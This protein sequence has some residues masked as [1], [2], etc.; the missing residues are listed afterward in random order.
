MIMIF[1]LL[2]AAAAT[3]PPAADAASHGP[4]Q[5]F[6]A[7]S[8]EPFRVYGDV[9]YP[10]ANW[11]TAADKNADGKLDLAEFT[12]DFLRFFDQ[13]DQNHDGAIDGIEKARY[14]NEVAPETTGASWYAKSQEQTNYEW[15]A[16][17][18][19]DVNLPKVDRPARQGQEAPIGA[20]R[21]DLLGLPEPV[22]SMD[23]EV[24]GRISRRMATDVAQMRFN[25]LDPQHR[26]FLTLDQLPRTPAEGRGGDRKRR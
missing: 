10:V 1:P 17:F 2:L 23:L 18:S 7:P 19:K 24:R 12:A 8:G 6:I 9:P 20:G 26:G 5:V 25:Q 16:G 15:N 13:L 3:E 4:P 14:E 22:A 11:F 21:F